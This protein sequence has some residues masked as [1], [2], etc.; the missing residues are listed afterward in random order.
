MFPHAWPSLENP[1]TVTDHEIW[2]PT[3]QCSPN[4][5]GPALQLS[6]LCRSLFAVDLEATLEIWRGVSAFLHNIASWIPQ[7]QLAQRSWRQ[8]DWC[9]YSHPCPQ[10]CC[11][12]A[13]LLGPCS[14]KRK[15][16]RE[17]V[18]AT[19]HKFWRGLYLNQCVLPRDC[20]PVWRRK[21]SVSSN[22]G[23]CP[24]TTAPSVQ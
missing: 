9:V 21:R 23:R 8:Q 3:E 6:I 15:A 14:G 12:P 13:L 22:S 16:S 11:A 20:I 7:H 17:D 24:D 2:F 4:Q 18:G 19:C 10:T 1:V 5:L